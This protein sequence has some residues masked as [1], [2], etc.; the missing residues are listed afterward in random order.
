MGYYPI[1]MQMAGR[2]VLLVGGGHVADEKIGKLVEA[3]ADV[4]VVAPRLIPQ[5]QRFID[6]GQARLRHREYCR[7]DVQGFEVVMIATDDGEVNRAV[8]AEARAAGIWVNA[9][10][11]VTNC[12]FILPSLARRGTITI[13]TSTGGASPALARWLRERMEEFLSNEVVALGDLLAEVRVLARDRDRDCAAG[14]ELTRTPP[15]LLCKQCP[16]RIPADH[17]QEA[18]AEVYPLLQAGDYA[19]ARQR[20]ISTLRLDQPLIRAPSTSAATPERQ[21][22]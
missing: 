15:P 12:D 18:I 13:A 22:S 20:M 5:V 9:A 4:T 2:R 16:N 11:D 6:E 17:W 1:L 7:G 19:G 8:A 10:D 3:G 21:T 14:C